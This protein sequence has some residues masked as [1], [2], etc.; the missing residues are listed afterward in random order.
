VPFT[1]IL[2]L[3][4]THGSEMVY[5]KLVRAVKSNV[6]KAD[7]IL[8][9]GDVTGKAIV[10][11]VENQPGRYFAYSLMAIGEDKKA[12]TPDELEALKKSFRS[13]GLYPVVLTPSE[14]ED[15]QSHPDKLTERFHEEMFRSLRAWIAQAETEVKPTGVKFYMMPGNDD[16]LPVTDVIKESTYVI[17][18][19]DACVHLDEHHEMISLGFSNPTPW[20]T[21]RE[22]SED[23]IARRIEDMVLQ[24]KDLKNC[25]FNFHVPPYDSTLDT[26]PVLDENLRPKA[27]MADLMRAPVG[28]TAVRA[29]IEKYQP[30][31]GLHGHIHESAG[32]IKI[33]RT[34]CINPGSEYHS[35]I[36]KAY[37]INLD[38]KGFKSHLRVEG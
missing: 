8:M 32:E 21:P 23:E 29:A 28:S 34:F 17:D 35:G 1:R 16:P 11:I 6:Y 22:C 25:V 18:P 9:S 4:D 24:V 27:T 7:S 36:F 14:Y 19:E 13:V 37:L 30:L 33:G 12:N 38:E 15:L 5:R 20:K 2:F 3:T 26:A 10:P 31:L